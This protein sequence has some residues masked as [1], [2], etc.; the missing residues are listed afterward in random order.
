[1]PAAAVDVWSFLHC[2]A[3]RAAIFASRVRLAGARGMSAFACFC[4]GHSSLH[5]QGWELKNQGRENGLGVLGVQDLSGCRSAA[6]SALAKKRKHLARKRWNVAGLP[7]AD[8]V[9]VTNHFLIRP[10]SSGIAK[11]ILNGVIAGYCA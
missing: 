6:R 4:C 5:L 1:M 9:T 11:V 8:P 7:T 3:L 2:F 10:G